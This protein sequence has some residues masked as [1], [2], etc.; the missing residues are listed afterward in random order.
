MQWGNL[1]CSNNCIFEPMSWL[2]E[3]RYFF[4][5]H[6]FEVSSRM[7]DKLGMK[8]K[9]VRLYFIYATFA[10]L[11]VWFLVYLFLAFW[12]KIKDLVFVKRSSVFDL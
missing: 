10:T 12:L 5:R 9:T 6:G 1:L 8:A 4:E 3:I 11:G 7:A 2:S